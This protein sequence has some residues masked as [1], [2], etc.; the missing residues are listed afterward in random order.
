MHSNMFREHDVTYS[1]EQIHVF[2]DIRFSFGLFDVQNTVIA[3]NAIYLE[4]G[5]MLLSERRKFKFKFKWKIE[6]NV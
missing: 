1:F 2:T 5:W 6:H 4:T 3:T